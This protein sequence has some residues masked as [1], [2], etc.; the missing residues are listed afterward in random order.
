[1]LKISRQAVHQYRRRSMSQQGQVVAIL[2]QVKALRQIMPRVGGRKLLHHLPHLGIGRDKFFDILRQYGLLVKRRRKYTITTSTD[3]TL[4]VYPNLLLQA[5]V[6]APNRFWVADQTYIRLRYGFCYLS[7]VTDLWSRKIVGYDVSPTL[8]AS[9][10]VNALR[11]ALSTVHDSRG[12][13]H[14]SDRG[15]QYCSDDYTRTLKEHGCRISMTA[16]RRPDQNA[17]AERVNGILKTEFYL[18]AT[19]N[20]IDTARHA[21]VQSI[22]IYNNIRLHLSL[23]MIT[24]SLKHAA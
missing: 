20:S 13:V 11:M 2:P 14:H 4:P 19:F 17:T 16:P 22:Y 23:G 8:E 21:I 12:L 24:P 7:L 9:G 18:D 5:A 3:H 1:M 6:D 15:K 10:P